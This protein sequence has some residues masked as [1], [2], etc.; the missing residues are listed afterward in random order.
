MKQ[1][2]Y[3]LLNLHTF[4]QLFILL[5][6]SIIYIYQLLAI[7]LLVSFLLCLLSDNLLGQSKISFENCRSEFGF[8][9]IKIYGKAKS[10]GLSLD[11]FVA[12]GRDKVL[13]WGFS[14]RNL[15]CVI[16]EIFAICFSLEKSCHLQILN[17]PNFN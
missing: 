2:C 15:F 5:L 14:F 17:L 3:S 12:Q 4:I 11:P 1:I 7:P 8:Q 16:F 13:V 9:D 6:Q 10:G